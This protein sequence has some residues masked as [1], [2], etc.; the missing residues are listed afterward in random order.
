MQE[1]LFNETE[2]LRKE[3]QRIYT[4]EGLIGKSSKMNDV[5]K[6][7][8]KIIPTDGRVIIEGESGTGKE[9]VARILHYNGPRKA[10]PF[11]AVDCGVLPENLIESELFGHIKGAFTGAGT[12]K[13]GLFE[14]ADGGT[15]FLDE[16]MNMSLDMQGK[17]LRVIQEHEF[18]AVGST[19]IKKVN[20]RLIVAASSGFLEKVEKHE[21]RE[22]LYYRLN[23]MKI[24]L[25]PLRDRKGDIPLLAHHFLKRISQEYNKKIEQFDISALSCFGR[26]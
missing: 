5:Y 16:I 17:L 23:V 18:R 25:P 3:A 11:V 1:K 22:D 7:L 19:E 4:Y 20:V 21:F 13:K 2:R 15:I 10:K 9:L 24:T 6:L 12:D 8:E 26:L 14:E